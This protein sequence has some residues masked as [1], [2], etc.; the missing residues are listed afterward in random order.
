MTQESMEDAFW[1][2]SNLGVISWASGKTLVR[3]LP[4]SF[5]TMEI[6][7]TRHHTLINILKHSNLVY[8]HRIYI[9]VYIYT[10]IW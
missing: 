8:N 4:K 1:L 9:Y 3:G 6:P 2:G 10:Y 5:K 7:E